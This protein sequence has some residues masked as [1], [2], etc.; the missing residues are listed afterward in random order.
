M[1][2][3]FQQDLNLD[4]GLDAQI[5]LTGFTT[6]LAQ[7]G[8]G[9]PGATQPT[10]VLDIR[11]TPEDP[12]PLVS[13][14]TSSGLTFGVAPPAP[15]GLTVT[16]QGGLAVVGASPT[17]QVGVS[18]TIVSTVASTTA[19]SNVATT[20][21]A[22]GN[23]AFVT[24][25]AGSYYIWSPGDPNTPNGTTVVA[26]AG[27]TGNWLLFGTLTVAVA[28]TLAQALLGYDYLQ[29]DLVVTWPNAAQTKLF[30][31]R[32]WVSTTLS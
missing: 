26:G 5:I 19:L 23:V 14:S 1:A 8:I 3:V 11:A 12:S 25:G 32:V 6:A 24:A 18:E 31:G 21:F 4:V 7:V 20:T 17:V 29:Y 10:A 22:L 13:L 27:S 28:A 9:L 2:A 30:A 16:E 15:A